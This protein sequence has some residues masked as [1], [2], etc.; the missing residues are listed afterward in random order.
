MYG[1][2][3]QKI[4]GVR[5]V[6]LGL[7]G[8]HWHGC[9]DVSD[10]SCGPPL[11]VHLLDVCQRDNSR[12]EVVFAHRHCPDAPSHEVIVNDVVAGSPAESAGLRPDDIIVGLEEASITSSGDL[13]EALRRYR[14]GAEVTVR[15]YR[16]GS[17]R[18][19]T[20]VLVDRPN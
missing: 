2:L 6:F 7:N 16:G 11:P 20:T 1:V 14:V 15:F 8:V 4:K 12:Q 13:L 17:E 18:E 5:E 9:H 10:G 3:R 19:A